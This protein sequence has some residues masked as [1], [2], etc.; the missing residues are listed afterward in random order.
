MKTARFFLFASVTLMLSACGTENKNELKVTATAYTSTHSQTDKTPFLA[1]WNNELEPGMKAIAVSRDL[2]QH[3]LTNG[4]K[5]T[6][7]G[8]PGEYIVLDKMHKRWEKK[9]DIYMGL[10]HQAAK[11]WGKQEV[12]I[13]WIAANQ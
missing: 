7:S 8:L 1:A 9:I 4:S 13:S 5:V 6:I 10:D 3:G 2:L 12:T 11:E